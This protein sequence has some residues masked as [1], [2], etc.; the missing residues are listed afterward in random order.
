MHERECRQTRQNRTAVA[1]IQRWLARYEKTTNWTPVFC[2]K[3]CKLGLSVLCCFLRVFRSKKAPKQMRARHRGRA[4][5]PGLPRPDPSLSGPP[6]V[7]RHACAKGPFSRRLSI[8][9]GQFDLRSAGQ[10]A[11]PQKLLFY[12]LAPEM[13]VAKHPLVHSR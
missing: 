7:A 10:Q 9:L 3:T 1:P 6:Q 2:F 12:L 13:G 4:P 5:T 8:Y 11:W